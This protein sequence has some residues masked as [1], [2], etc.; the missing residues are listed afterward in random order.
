MPYKSRDE[1]IEVDDAP[2]EIDPYAVLSVEQNATADHIKS[3]YR[4]AALKH[5][6]DKAS[7]DDKDA[8]HAKFQEVAFAYAILSDERRRKR[9]DTTGNTSES[10]DLDDDDFDWTSFFRE[11]Y[12]SAVTEASINKFAD[13]YKGS[14]EEQ[15]HVLDAYEKVKGNM[16]AIY[17]RVMLSDM[18]DDEERFRVII[19]KAIADGEVE[20]YKKYADE[21]EPSRKKRIDRARKRKEK[22]AKEAL[23]AEEEME[24]D[25]KS[26]KN[27]SKAKSGGAGDTNELA[28]LIQQRQQGRSAESFIAGLEAKYAGETKGDRGK[29]GAKRASPDEPSEEA[30]AKNRAVGKGDE[31]DAA[32]GARRSKRSRKA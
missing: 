25:P 7:L 30:F 5:H 23:K 17:G 31:G 20:S 13:E 26:K 1:D 28:A 4:K 12:K 10:L 32:A 11:Q 18:V 27:K 21:S 22:D 14:E 8:A 9:Y 15:R 29:M 3:A 6:P 16:E 24:Q 19:D 2:T